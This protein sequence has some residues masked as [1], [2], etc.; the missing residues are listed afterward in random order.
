[1]YINANDTNAT[2]V[3]IRTEGFT[4]GDSRISTIVNTIYDELVPYRLNSVISN[5]L[6]HNDDPLKILKTRYVK[7]EI[8]KEEYGEMKQSL[9]D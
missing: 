4:D 2:E 3:L 5:D 9:I 8:T 7:G 6:S 1:M